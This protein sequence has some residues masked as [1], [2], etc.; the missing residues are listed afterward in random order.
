M[1]TRRRSTRSGEGKPPRVVLDTNVVLS[2]LVFDQGTTARLR[3]A[4]QLGRCVPLIS[5]ATAQELVR[6]LAYPKF[7]L[8]SAAQQEL[9]AD[10]LPY[11][12]VV[13]IP[14]PPPIVPACRDVF[15]LPFLYLAVTGRAEI[16]VTG[17]TDLLVLADQVRYAI[18]TPEAFLNHLPPIVPPQT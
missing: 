4:W 10:Y 6:V 17:D 11:A 18:V 2:A 7:R 15:D 8:D 3:V 9:L 16:L 13:C 5:T 14:E 12:E 1:I